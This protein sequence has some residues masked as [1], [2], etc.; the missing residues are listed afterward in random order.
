MSGKDETIDLGF[1]LEIAKCHGGER[2]DLCYQCGTCT[3]GCPSARQVEGFNPRRFVEDI[4]LG[5]KDQLLKN[6][7][8]WLCTTC[9]TCLE[10]C[11]QGIPVS[12]LFIS[13][14]N[15]AAKKG[16]LPDGLKAEAFAII[17]E[18]L[19]TPVTPGIIRRRKGMGL[20]QIPHVLTSEIRKIVKLTRFDRLVG[21][22]WGEKKEEV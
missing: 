4:L 16:N 21:Y 7:K 17:K 5:S 1:R 22:N 10:R 9:H 11:P 6:S 14:K 19:T 13:I 15:L 18:G 2:V 20:P 3:G 8:I 12:E